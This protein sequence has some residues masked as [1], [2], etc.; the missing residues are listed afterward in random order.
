MNIILDRKLDVNKT[1][2]NY[3]KVLWFYDFWSRL[4]ESKAFKKVIELADV[5]DNQSIIEI[6]CGTGRLFEKIVNKNPNGY[7]I[8]L[9]LSPN[10]LHKAD[11]RLQKKGLRNYELHEA[12]IL[13]LNIEFESFDLLINNFMID[14]M[15]ESTFDN[16][17][18]EFYRLLKSNGIALIST[19][20]FGTKRIHR[21]WFWMAK[22]APGLL[23]GCR[24]VT[25]K[26]YLE[27]AGFEIIDIYQISQNTF[28][29]EIIKVK[30]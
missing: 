3:R 9:D 20:S 28:P 19:F 25:F 13:D 22:Y 8:G 18:N 15:P 30:K 27:K 21:F 12:N 10:M 11:I 1:L 16:I 7:N 23:T 2:I 14:L 24:P 6:A 26:N 5:K 29:A 17:A 4:T